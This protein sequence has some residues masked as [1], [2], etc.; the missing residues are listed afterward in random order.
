MSAATEH[1]H[2]LA[3]V[4]NGSKFLMKPRLASLSLYTLSTRGKTL[5]FLLHL[6]KPSEG[7]ESHTLT[8]VG[9]NEVVALIPVA[10]SLVF[11]QSI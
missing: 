4:M 6:L 9:H 10:W 5:S 1:Y 8:H 7:G 2:C 3:L 11:T